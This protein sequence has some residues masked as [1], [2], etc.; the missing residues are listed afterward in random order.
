MKGILADNDVL[1][2]VEVLLHIWESDD[3]RDIWIGT[4]LSLFS[5]AAL[6]L[7]TDSADRLLW[8]TCQAHQV[9][10]ITGNRND[11]GPDSLESTIRDL[12]S[13]TTLP[14]ITLANPKRIHRDRIYAHLV[15][16]KTLEYL[17]DVN[18]FLGSGRLYVP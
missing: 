7:P 16:E 4:G 13:A 15:A 11:E 2:Q 18:D 8:Q 6:G 3:W 17:L 1:G 5:F 14:V 10:L 9:V 12:N